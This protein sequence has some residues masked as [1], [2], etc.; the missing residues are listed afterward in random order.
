M[1]L[2]REPQSVPRS[3]T[4]GYNDEYGTQP[5]LPAPYDAATGAEDDQCLQG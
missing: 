5:D 4:R 3:R 2:H 1:M